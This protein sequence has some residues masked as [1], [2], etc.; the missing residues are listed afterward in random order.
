MQ[1]IEAIIRPGKLNEITEA[2]ADAGVL[3][4]TV[5]NVLGCGRQKGH[6][7]VY[8]GQEVQIRLLPKVKLEIACLETQSEQIVEVITR[9]ARTGQVGDGK[10]FISPVQESIRIRTGERGETAL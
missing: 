2:L 10:I 7:Q 4:I 6:T 5:S 1:K 8:R 9:L 3:G